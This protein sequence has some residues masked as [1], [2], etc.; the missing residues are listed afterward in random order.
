MLMTG[1]NV[2]DTCRWHFYRDPNEVKRSVSHIS[3]FPDGPKKLA[4]AYSRLEF[5]SAAAG[6]STSAIESYIWDIGK[7]E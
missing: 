1:E 3:W 6:S 4:V 7:N 5:Q 2:P